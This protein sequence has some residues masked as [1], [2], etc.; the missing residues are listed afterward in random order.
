VVD[1]DQLM[2][3]SRDSAIDPARLQLVERGAR[4]RLVRVSPQHHPWTGH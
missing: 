4:M 2:E 1:A 3:L